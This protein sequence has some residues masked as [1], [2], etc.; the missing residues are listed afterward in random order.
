MGDLISEIVFLVQ[1]ISWLTLIDLILVSSI[2]YVILLL[3]KDTQAQT[4]MRGVIFIIVLISLLTT[5]V[6]LPAFSWL[7][8]TTLPAL[9]FAIP[10]LFM[11][12]IRRGLE[13]LGRAGQAH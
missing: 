9:L 7:V 6:N 8:N 3:I 4:L 2:F 11:P 10:V 13:R 12:E 1:R 5:L